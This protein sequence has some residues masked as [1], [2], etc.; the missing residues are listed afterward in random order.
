MARATY[1]I[2]LSETFW[3]DLLDPHCACI[4]WACTRWDSR[5]DSGAHRVHR[6]GH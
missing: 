1:F 5:P 2:D 6:T 4:S 3:G